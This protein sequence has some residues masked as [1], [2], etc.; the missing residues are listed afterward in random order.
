MK[1]SLL[2]IFAIA[3]L[4]CNN[5]NDKLSAKDSV[6]S[7]INVIDTLQNNAADTGVNVYCYITGIE[8]LHDSIM[9]KADYVDFFQGP[10]VVDEAKKRHRADTAYDKNGKIQDIFVPDDYFIVN[11]DKTPL[12][13][14]LPA[15][16]PIM[17]DTE[18]AGTRTGEINT[19][20]YFSKHYENSLFLLRVKQKT[21]TLVK[22]VF[23]P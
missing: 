5:S 21:V 12:T 20:A 18:I 10:N 7:K 2:T 11:D 4:S 16:T 15:N 6:A 23:L 8:K 14:Y 17:M 9:L 22:E 19:Y 3:L 1:V 13:L